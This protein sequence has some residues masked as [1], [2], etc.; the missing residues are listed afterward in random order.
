MTPS[1]ESKFPPIM[2]ADNKTFELHF[3]NSTEEKPLD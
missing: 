3:L 1:V 2:D